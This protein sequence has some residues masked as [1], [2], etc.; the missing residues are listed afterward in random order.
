[1]SRSQKVGANR[2]VLRSRRE[3]LE[4]LS[5]RS[6]RAQDRQAHAPEPDPEP[7]ESGTNKSLENMAAFSLKPAQ[8]NP[9]KTIDY[10][11]SVVLI[12]V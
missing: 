11:S 2:P 8:A 10:S 3:L 5:P 12:F 1:M 9:G 7:E 6:Q 4:N